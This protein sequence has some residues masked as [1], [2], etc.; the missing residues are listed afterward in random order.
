MSI[1]GHLMHHLHCHYMVHCPCQALE[2]KLKCSSKFFA[3]VLTFVVRN[4]L[5]LLDKYVKKGE[6]W[7]AK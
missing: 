4:L 5:Q 2:L 3:S 7:P 1:P 6:K